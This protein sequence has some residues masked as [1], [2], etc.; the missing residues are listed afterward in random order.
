MIENTARYVASLIQD[1]ATYKGEGWEAMK[2]MVGNYNAAVIE[3]MDSIALH[4]FGIFLKEMLSDEETAQF[5]QFVMDA[6]QKN[7][8]DISDV[9][10]VW[11][12]KDYKQA[13]A[14]FNVKIRKQK[15]LNMQMQQQGV[16]VQMKSEQDMNAMKMQLAQLD[17]ETKKIV[18]DLAGNKA[19]QL[20]QLKQTGNYNQHLVDSDLKQQQIKTKVAAE[21]QKDLI[22]QANEPKEK[23][24][25]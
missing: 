21:T 7:E 13:V 23:A 2:Q 1:M 24:A 15:M 20:Q 11:F 16:Q 22:L 5:K 18:T 4:R 14:L 6:Y 17:A 10:L 25:A 12:M 9:L 19:L 3:S 8:I